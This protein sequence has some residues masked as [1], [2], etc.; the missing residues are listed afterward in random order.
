MIVSTAS[1]WQKNGGKGSE[2]D[3]GVVE[4]RVVDL[5]R[6]Y[7]SRVVFDPRELI[8]SAQ[9]W[10]KAG[11][12]VAE[13]V[14]SVG[15]NTKLALRPLELVRAHRLVLPDDDDLA[16]E[17]SR[18]RITERGPGLF[19]ID[20]TPGGDGHGDRAVAIGMAAMALGERTPTTV[21]SIG[22]TKPR[23]RITWR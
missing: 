1:C 5:A 7:R 23:G 11:L 14:F 20:T 10:R 17:L 6:L 18:I 19:K 22:S 8:S 12:S 15:S 16:D 13:H 2:L 3:V 4:Q 9:R 21:A